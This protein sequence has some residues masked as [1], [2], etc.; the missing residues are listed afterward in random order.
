MIEIP[1]DHFSILRQD[2]EDM[3]YIVNALKMALGAGGWTLSVPLHYLP[4][5]A[6]QE[7]AA[8]TAEEVLD[9]AQQLEEIGVTDPD[10]HAHLHNTL[11]PIDE[12]T[13]GEAMSSL[14]RARAVVP[15]NSAARVAMLSERKRARSPLPIYSGDEEENQAV[16]E[17][18]LLVED[19][20]SS[21]RGMSRAGSLP[22]PPPGAELRPGEAYRPVSALSVREPYL[23]GEEEE[24]LPVVLLCTDANGGVSGLQQFLCGVQLPVYAVTLPL[25]DAIAE[26]ESIEELAELVLKAARAQVWRR[27]PGARLVFA[28]VGFGGVI[29]FEAAVQMH[30]E[31]GLS[32][33]LLL[34]DG[35][36]TITEHLEAFFWMEEE[37]DAA[38]DDL[39]Q[40]AT[41]LHPT[42]AQARIHGKP[43]L[44]K[45]GFAARLHSLPSYE[46][47]LDFIAQH[48]PPEETQEAWDDKIHALLT[49]LYYYRTLT[50]TYVPSR[51]LPGE[52]LLFA[53]PGEDRGWT[54]GSMHAEWGP[55]GVWEAIR[56]STMPVEV[57]NFP[58]GLYEEEKAAGW[59]GAGLL[60]TATEMTLKTN[61]IPGGAPP[62]QAQAGWEPPPRVS[63]LQEEHR[64][65]RSD[66]QTSEK[67]QF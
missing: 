66:E 3:Q 26:T 7:A 22:A 49:R 65:H 58:S 55:G 21:E 12:A 29:A 44:T 61:W 36:G 62:P 60:E 40:I 19:I 46:A 34:F 51:H 25:D 57:L 11:Q 30:R 32:C 5:K 42:I 45:E 20:E 37:S 16:V 33:P 17:G 8:E 13:N 47:Q 2:S 1:G 31:T 39:A 67:K 53:G 35:L 15:V 10:L 43:V 50:A 6:G 56:A 59:V 14:A 23:P 24:D 9:F 48:K 38:A 54:G 18:A 4:A 41:L 63:G 64:G 28:G 27:R 52:C